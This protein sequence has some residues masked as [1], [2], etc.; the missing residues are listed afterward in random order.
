MSISDS[1]F[2]QVAYPSPVATTLR[3]PIAGFFNTLVIV[4]IF[5]AGILPGISINTGKFDSFRL[6]FPSNFILAGFDQRQPPAFQHSTTGILSYI[7]TSDDATWT[8]AVDEVGA[9]F[10]ETGRHCVDY[11]SSHQNI[12]EV[13]S[14]AI[15]LTSWV[16]VN[17]PPI[18]HSQERIRSISLRDRI[19]LGGESLKISMPLDRLIQTVQQQ[20]CQSQDASDKSRRRKKDS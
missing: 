20:G 19:W 9:H 11:K 7:A 8:Y 2:A 14:G 3:V 15:N 12:R 1:I 6:T 16:L 17:E 10:D 5:G 13:S 4:H 18:Q